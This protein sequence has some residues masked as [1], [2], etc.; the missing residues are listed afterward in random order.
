[1]SSYY[2]LLL[3]IL[4]ILP[5]CAVYIIKKKSKIASSLQ[6]Q[7]LRYIFTIN[8][9]IV[10]I[11]ILYIVYFLRTGFALIH[12]D[13]ISQILGNSYSIAQ[14]YH[15]EAKEKILNDILIIARTLNSQTDNFFKN[16]GAIKNLIESYSSLK[17][18]SEIVIFVPSKNLIL[19]RNDLSFSLVFDYIPNHYLL[20]TQINKPVIIENLNYAKIRALILLE[21]FSSPT[22]LMISRYMDEKITQYLL[23]SKDAM[24]SYDKLTD[25]INKMQ[26][27]FLIIFC[28]SII[29]SIVLVKFLSNIL[30]SQL[31]GPVRDFVNLAANK[32]LENIDFDNLPQRKTQISEINILIESFHSIIKKLNNSRREIDANSNFIQAIF[33]QTP[34]GLIVVAKNHEIIM[35]NDAINSLLKIADNNFIRKEFFKKIFDLIDIYVDSEKDCPKDG[36]EENIHIL[37]SQNHQNYNFL[38][39]LTEAVLSVDHQEQKHFLVIF[40]DITEHLAY[41]RNNLWIDVARRITHEIRNPLTPIIL[42]AERIEHKYLQ[43]I[44]SSGQENFLK[45]LENI[46][47]HTNTISSIIDEFVE[48]GKMPEPKFANVNLISVIKEAIQGGY[49]DKKMRY[50]FIC[51]EQEIIICADGQQIIRVLLNIFKNSWEA[52][53]GFVSENCLSIRIRLLRNNNFINLIIEDNGPGFPLKILDKITEPYITTKPKGSGLGLSIVKRIINDHEGQIEFKNKENGKGAQI[54]IIFKMING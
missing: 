43:C 42:S 49:F 32:S 18:L 11:T 31:V 33:R 25:N 26:N 9:T 7:I 51:S 20:E 47:R 14:A 53:A 19:A 37:D 8:I 4:L 13:N 50:D 2:F 12:N 23:N 24:D 28:V 52:C 46:K 29:V 22:Y 41:Q 40:N 44:D 48:F 45:Y 16:Q 17:E 10:L 27:I 21:G 39:K 34:H 30:T 5:I 35:Q 15:K 1:M 36:I 54:I 6:T 3:I 38:V